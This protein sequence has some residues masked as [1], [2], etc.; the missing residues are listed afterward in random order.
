VR[1]LPWERSWRESRHRDTRIAVDGPWINGEGMVVVYDRFTGV[2]LYSIN[3]PVQAGSPLHFGRSLDFDAGRL[4][5][6]A[7]G[8]YKPGHIGGRAYVFDVSAY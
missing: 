7:S 8:N 6:G 4:L 5:V 3:S 1:S 2:M